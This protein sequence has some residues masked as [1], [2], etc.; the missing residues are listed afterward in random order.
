MSRSKQRSLI[1]G[2]GQSNVL[3]VPV[4][5]LTIQGQG[6]RNVLNVPVVSLTIRGQGQSNVLNEPVVSFTILSLTEDSLCL[7]QYLCY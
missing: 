7:S 5:S 4:V 3:N 1:Q 6:Q 2:Q